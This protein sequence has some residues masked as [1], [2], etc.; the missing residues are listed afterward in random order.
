MQLV[1]QAR[2]H[3]TTTLVSVDIEA[4]QFRFGPEAIEVQVPHDDLVAFGGQEDRS[5][6]P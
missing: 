6:R 1:H 5:R 4:V 3:P 2:P